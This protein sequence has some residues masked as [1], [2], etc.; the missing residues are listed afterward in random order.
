MTPEARFWSKVAIGPVSEHRP[1]LGP[2][3]IWTGSRNAAG[4]GTFWWNGSMLAHRA[5]Y[6]L[7]R[8]FIPDLG[9]D[10]LCRVSAC[11]RPIHLEPVSNQIN[12]MRGVEAR[13]R[14]THC[15]WGH[16]FIGANLY[17]KI[18]YNGR[19]H[20]QCRVC[21]ARGNVAR[22]TRGGEEFKGRH[23]ASEA[24]RRQRKEAA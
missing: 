14:Q 3:W 10:H 2:C 7:A 8:G 16:P 24:R 1:D 15:K 21:I 6:R 5:A 22:A 19:Q 4:Y 13:P 23:A 18:G 9:L 20:Q 11:V 17:I 12:T